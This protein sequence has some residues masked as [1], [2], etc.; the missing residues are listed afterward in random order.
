MTVK[1]RLSKLHVERGGQ[2]CVQNPTKNAIT[3]KLEWWFVRPGYIDSCATSQLFWYLY[4]ESRVF[5]TYFLSAVRYAYK[6]MYCTTTCTTLIVCGILL[7]TSG[8]RVQRSNMAI[9]YANFFSLSLSLSLS[10]LYLLIYLFIFLLF[11]VFLQCNDW[12][13]YLFIYFV[14]NF[15]TFGIME[16]IESIEDGSLRMLK[17]NTTWGGEAW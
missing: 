8:S 1:T 4:V 14:W 11:F 7:H 2:S 17:V 9:H 16:M 15:T 10:R 3:K 5:V 13:I 12:F 6:Y